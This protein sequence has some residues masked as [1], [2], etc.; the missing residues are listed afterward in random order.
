M[1]L[2]GACGLKATTE[3]K[4]DCFVSRYADDDDEVWKRINLG[5]GEIASDAAWVV[6]SAAR[7]KGRTTGGSSLSS[8]LGQ[9]AANNSAPGQ[10]SPMHPLLGGQGGAIG[11]G[12][13]AAAP[14]AVVAE[15]GGFGGAAA[16]GGLTWVQTPDEIEASM[17]LPAEVGKKDVKVKFSADRLELW[18]AGA[19]EPFLAGKLG[20]AVDLDGCT[21]T[22][23]ARKG[24]TL[25]VSLEKKDQGR[26]WPFALKKD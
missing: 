5:K 23:D 13:A 25:V 16:D 8:I 22:L 14:A 15:E 1:G 18:L 21:W 10:P 3:V 6:A 7:N 2:M 24:N 20:G 26:E 9:V 12:L 17:A 4:G 19:A 11:P